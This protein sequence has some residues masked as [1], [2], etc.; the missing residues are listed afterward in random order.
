MSILKI[1]IGVPGSGKSTFAREFAMEEDVIVSSDSIR[2]TLFGDESC[3]ADNGKVFKLFHQQTRESLRKGRT[4]WA[5]ATNINMKSRRS[6]IGCARKKS[7]EVW[8]YVFLTPYRKCCINDAV[9]DRSVG[10][11]VIQKMIMRFQMPILEEG[12]DKIFYIYDDAVTYSGLNE[13]KEWFISKAKGF[14]QKSKWHRED[15][16]EHCLKAR[17]I[18]ASVSEDQTFIDAAF[19]HDCGKLYT[20]T[21]EKG[22]GYHFFNHQNYGAYDFLTKVNENGNMTSEIY[23]IA[24]LINY[25]DS[26]YQMPPKTL[27]KRFS[28]HAELLS[29]FHKVD[30]KASVRDEGVVEHYSWEEK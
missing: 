21:Y 29:A 5:D 13:Y 18:V 7:D 6:V 1:L 22:K 26:A 14:E 20:R 30:V 23:E 28:D 8:A 19:L 12:F 4:V 10:L 11:G 27:K 24:Y 17:N 2:L 15:L 25:H 3:Q 16:L 9:R